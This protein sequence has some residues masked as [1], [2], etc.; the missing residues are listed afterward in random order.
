M[1]KNIEKYVNS[2][3]CGNCLEIL[4]DFPDSCVDL[5]LTD[6]PFP[7]Y[8]IDTF[9]YKDGLLVFLTQYNCRQFVFWSAKVDFPLDYTSVHIWDKI[10]RCRSEYERIFERNGHKKHKVFRY[11]CIGNE[12]DAMFM[13]DVYTAHP[14]QKPIKLMLDMVGRYSKSNDLIL[15]PFCGSGTTCVAAKLLN[16]KYIGIDI[17]PEYCEIARKRIKTVETGVPMKE[18]VIGQLALWK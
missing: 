4:K 9:N 6:P 7:D 15:D 13:K 14:T 17:S 18:Q 12:I 8:H 5:V 3:I 11:H 1:D 2:I 16:R 10:T